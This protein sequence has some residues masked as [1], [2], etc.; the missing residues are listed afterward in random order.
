MGWAKYYEDISEIVDERRDSYVYDRSNNYT[1]SGIQPYQKC[2]TYVGTSDVN[3]N[4]N[5]YVS[6]PARV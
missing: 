4:T 1:P 5:K 3:K 2:T 6:N